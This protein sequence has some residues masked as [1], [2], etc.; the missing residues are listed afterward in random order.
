MLMAN[1]SKD[2]AETA[3]T[4]K[5]LR[6]FGFLNQKPDSEYMNLW[7]SSQGYKRIPSPYVNIMSGVCNSYAKSA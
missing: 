5:G 3:N 2:N 6:D 4:I 7:D 1:E